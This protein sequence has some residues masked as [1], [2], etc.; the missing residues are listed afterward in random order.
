MKCQRL[1]GIVLHYISNK[2]KWLILKYEKVKI[3]G[4]KNIQ[5]YGFHKVILI[6]FLIISYSYINNSG[7]HKSCI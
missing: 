2:I 5:K 4:G 6:Y 3:I 7:C 1:E